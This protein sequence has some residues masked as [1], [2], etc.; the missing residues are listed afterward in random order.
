MASSKPLF[1]PHMPALLIA[2]FLLLNYSS[3]TRAAS[4]LGDERDKGIQ[5]GRSGETTRGRRLQLSFK[6][7]PE[8]TN[9]TFDCSPSGSCVSC[10]YSEK[11]D[12]K[13]QCSETGYHLPYK[14]IENQHGSKVAQNV[15]SKKSR[16]LLENSYSDKEAHE[17]L[18]DADEDSS[19]II[20]RRFLDDSSMSEGG[21]QAYITY[22]S[23]IPTGNEESLSMLGFEGIV[24]CLLFGSGS[25]VYFRRKRTA[26][27]SGAGPNLPRIDVESIIMEE[28]LSPCVVLLAFSSISA[29]LCVLGSALVKL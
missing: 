1:I 7:T 29:Q 26:A 10:L 23:C 16:S 18:Q 9:V 14:C 19:S 2:I 11:N 6:E 25:F 24:L 27:M 4:L 20:Y 17:I 21:R 3:P 13:Y 28:L 15:K 12:E 22:R 8:G 5:G